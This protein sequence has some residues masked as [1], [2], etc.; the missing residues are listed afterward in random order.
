MGTNYYWEPSVPCTTCGRPFERVHIGKAS[1]GWTFSFHGT[2]QIRSYSDWLENLTTGRIVNEYGNE[3]SLD[4][5][6]DT[7]EAKMLWNGRLALNHARLALQI[8][9]LNDAERD[10][11][12]AHPTDFS[13]WRKDMQRDVW[14]DKDG[15]SFG[16]YE[17]S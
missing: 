5:F 1:A 3:V 13:G 6:K 9:P 8:E 7:V 2:E 15:H 4:E 12:A 17:F 10:Y 16:G 11:R 14:L